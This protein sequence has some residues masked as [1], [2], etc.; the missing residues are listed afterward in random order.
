MLRP[1]FVS[2]CMSGSDHK[3]NFLF[4]EDPC[5][6]SWTDQQSML[7]YWSQWSKPGPTLPLSVD[8]WIATRSCNGFLQQWDNPVKLFGFVNG[9][10][11]FLGAITHSCKLHP[12]WLIRGKLLGVKSWRTVD[13]VIFLPWEWLRLSSSGSTRVSSAMSDEERDLLTSLMAKGC[14]YCLC[15]NETYLTSR[16]P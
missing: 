4:L 1:N 14:H 5:D 15:L 2:D 6:F 11:L 12:L 13:N 7:R 10:L 16:A 3:Y 8:L 9:F